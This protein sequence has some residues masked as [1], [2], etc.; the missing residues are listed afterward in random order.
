MRKFKSLKVV[1]GNQGYDFLMKKTDGA[2]EKFEVSSYIDGQE[3]TKISQK[4]NEVADKYDIEANE[5]SSSKCQRCSGSYESGFCN[6]CGGA[7]PARVNESNQNRANCEMCQ[8]NG[9]IEGYNG[10]KTC[11]V[12]NGTGKDSY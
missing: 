3:D 7:S 11:P 6:M 10:V 1:L 5:S 8:G 4:L 12:C 9:Y 2:V